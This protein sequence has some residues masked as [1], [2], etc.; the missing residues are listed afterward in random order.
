MS[1]E[2]DQMCDVMV[3]AFQCDFHVIPWNIISYLGPSILTV[4]TYV[5][6]HFSRPWIPSIPQ[7]FE[8]SIVSLATTQNAA[9]FPLQVFSPRIVPACLQQLVFRYTS[10][11]PATFASI[12]SRPK[13][14][15]RNGQPTNL[16]STK[17][18]PDSLVDSATHEVF[19]TQPRQAH[20]V[21]K[22]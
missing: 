12:Q 9:A 16:L 18:H 2:C 22:R 7:T 13:S 17:S 10:L 21:T 5:L 8:L 15:S 1:K 20:T 6:P 14:N 11:S 19:P 3:S 4:G